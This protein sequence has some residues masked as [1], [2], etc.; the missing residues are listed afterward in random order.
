[1]L[2]RHRPAIERGRHEHIFVEAGGRFD[3]G[4]IYPVLRRNDEALALLRT[5]IASPEAT[6]PAG[7]RC[8]PWL[9]RLR[10]DLRFDE[11]LKAAKSL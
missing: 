1:M 3:I 10:D 11:I 5:V 7:F 4:R 8:D 6:T 2:A 9:A